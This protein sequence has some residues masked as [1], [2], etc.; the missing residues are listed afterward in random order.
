MCSAM[1]PED[2]LPGFS[3]RIVFVDE[4]NRIVHPGGEDS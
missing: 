2:E 1:V 3:P 4:N